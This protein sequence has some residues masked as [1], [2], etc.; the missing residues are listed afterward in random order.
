MSSHPLNKTTL[1]SGPMPTDP[2]NKDA[3]DNSEER[4]PNS[5]PPVAAKTLIT[6]KRVN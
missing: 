6:T 5:P 4:N 3:N 2:K 1:V